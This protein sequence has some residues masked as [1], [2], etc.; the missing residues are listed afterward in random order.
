M[1]SSDALCLQTH[2]KLQMQISSDA[3]RFLFLLI[4]LTLQDLF[5]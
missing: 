1:M 5:C 3:S 2:F 4:P